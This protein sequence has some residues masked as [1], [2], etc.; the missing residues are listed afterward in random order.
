MLIYFV[1][2]WVVSNFLESLSI[3]TGFPFGEYPYM[4][5]PI[6]IVGVPI[7]IMPTYFAQSYVALTMAQALLGVFNK[8]I[9]G[10]YKC[11]VPLTAALVMT[12]WDVISDPTASTITGGWTWKTGGEFFGVPVTTLPVG[13]CVYT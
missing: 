5:F 2:T 7:A 8:K 1:I 9:K 10:V 6:N 4:D 13:H 12:M 3:A 11:I